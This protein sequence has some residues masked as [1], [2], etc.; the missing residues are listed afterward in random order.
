SSPPSLREDLKLKLYL[1]T[2]SAALAAAQGTSRPAALHAVTSRPVTFHKDIE[3]ILQN[4]CQ[5]CHRPG[6]IAPMPL[7]NYAETR[8]WAKAIREAVLTGKMPPWHA[9]PHYGKF[10]NDLSLAP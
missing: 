5:G 6:E 4:R 9:D 8:P 2:L 3:P 1:A 10:S 7:L